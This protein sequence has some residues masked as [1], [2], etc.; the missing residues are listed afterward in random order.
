M[1][2]E[3]VNELV[4]FSSGFVSFI[5]F[6]IWAWLGRIIH[7]YYSWRVGDNTTK[8]SLLLIFGELPIAALMGIS[9][10]GIIEYAVQQE[11]IERNELLVPAI[12]VVGSYIGPRLFGE[13]WR[14]YTKNSR[15][16]NIHIENTTENLSFDKQVDIELKTIHEIIETLNNTIERIREKGEEPNENILENLRE[17]KEYASKLEREREEK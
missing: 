9:M 6:M 8:F 11:W 2:K 14:E 4:S 17:L 3:I 5:N 13:L 7:L 1:L 10:G 12:I 16:T 15:E